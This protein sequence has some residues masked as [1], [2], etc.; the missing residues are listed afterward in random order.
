MKTVKQNKSMVF[1]P[2]ELKTPP[3]PS[4]GKPDAGFGGRVRPTEDRRGIVALWE[5][6]GEK[7]RGESEVR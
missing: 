7:E 4:P 2:E 6:I 5:C 1:T 3:S